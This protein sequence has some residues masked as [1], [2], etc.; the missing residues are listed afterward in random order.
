MVGVAVK[1]TLVPVQMA[2]A[3]TAAI[4][5][6]G[7]TLLF[8]TIVMVFDVAVVDD[9]QLPPVMLISQVTVCPLASVVLV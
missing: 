8:T 7:V 6:V 9:K 1:V 2:P 4:E 5:T 3:G